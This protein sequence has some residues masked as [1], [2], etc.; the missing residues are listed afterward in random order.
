[1][2]RQ[3]KNFGVLDIPMSCSVFLEPA[4]RRYAD[5]IAPMNS[6]VHE[7]VYEW[8]RALLNVIN[9]SKYLKHLGTVGGAIAKNCQR[10]D[11]YSKMCVEWASDISAQSLHYAIR[12][13]E[14]LHFINSKLA[15]NKN[16]KFV[17]FGCGMS[18]FAPYVAYK[19]PE[20]VAYCV[21]LPPIIDVFYETTESVAPGTNHP[22][23][24]TWDKTKSMAQEHKLDAL[25]A[26]GV[27]PHIDMQ[28]QLQD[29]HFI[30]LYFTNFM[31]ELKYSNDIDNRSKNS[32]N[33]ITLQ[34][35]RM[36]VENVDT[37]ETAAI[38]NSMRYLHTFLAACPSKRWF[39]EHDRSLFIS[40]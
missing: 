8:N 18:P 31:I 29:L 40:R 32:F 4:L 30:N 39:L 13:S 1:M 35:L 9:Q 23:P 34:N 38:Q 21:D 11:N 6:D 15:Q 33:P 28:E 2:A 14:S 5:Y 25:V 27:F 22:T 3:Q 17:D 24:I 36:S 16:L 20:S 26:M 12:F 19:N 37:L 7:Y 10:F